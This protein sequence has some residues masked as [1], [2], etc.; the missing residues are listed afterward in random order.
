MA[1]S[2]TIIVNP[3]VPVRGLV[4]MA[5]ETIIFDAPATASAHEGAEASVDQVASP[6][7]EELLV[8]EVSIDGMCGVY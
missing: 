5:A 6:E 7:V 4:I 8:E 3:L 1:S 2:A